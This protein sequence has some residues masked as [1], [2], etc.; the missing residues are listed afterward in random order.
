MPHLKVKFSLSTI[1][2]HKND[3][4]FG[5]YMHKFCINWSQETW[6][7][8]KQHL[9]SLLKRNKDTGNVNWNGS[10]NKNK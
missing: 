9:V 10:P 4:R 6:T 5:V 3:I 8:P 7:I 1:V 2:W